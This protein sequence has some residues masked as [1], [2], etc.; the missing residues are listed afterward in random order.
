MV[1]TRMVRLTCWQR[2]RL[3]RTFSALLDALLIQASFR[4]G[5]LEGVALLVEKLSHGDYQQQTLLGVGL[6]E[7]ERLAGDQQWR[8]IS[9]II[10]GRQRGP[11]ASNA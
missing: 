11:E 5:D 10:G 3:Q 2:S 7:A 1:K 4:R 6:G 8:Y 9:N